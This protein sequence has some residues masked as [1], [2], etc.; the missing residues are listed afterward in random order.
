MVSLPEHLDL[1]RTHFG[2]VPIAAD[3]MVNRYDEYRARGLQNFLSPSRRALALMNAPNQALSIK[4]R[5]FQ[6]LEKTIAVHGVPVSER[7]G[8][9]S[10]IHHYEQ[11]WR[12][13]HSLFTAI[14]AALQGAVD[15]RNFGRE[16][17]NGEVN[18]L[19]T[20]L[21]SRGTLHIKVHTSAVTR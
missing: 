18:D 6:A 1:V 14:A 10:Y 21:R 8:F 5:D 17:P 4:V 20:M 13:A 2:S 3:H 9:Y 15:V 12:R 19:A 11:R 7:R 16:S